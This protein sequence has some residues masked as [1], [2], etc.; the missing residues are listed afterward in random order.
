MI[1]G[2][3]LNS[4]IWHWNNM[5]QI[6]VF[7]VVSWFVLA[8]LFLIH[9]GQTPP[10]SY[11]LFLRV[12][13]ALYTKAHCSDTLF[14]RRYHLVRAWEIEIHPSVAQ[15][16]DDFGREAAEKSLFLVVFVVLIMVCCNPVRR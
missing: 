7:S 13:R 12:L 8:S 4:G 5:S 14:E 10:K 9:S 6:S 1:G 15:Q 11:L 3:I 16:C 2:N